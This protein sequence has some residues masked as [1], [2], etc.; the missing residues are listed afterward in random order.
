M[1]SIIALVRQRDYLVQAIR[2]TPG[3]SYSPA[4]DHRPSFF[5]ASNFLTTLICSTK[6][7]TSSDES[8]G[9]EED[10]NKCLSLRIEKLP[11]GVTVGSAL[12]S[13]MGDGFPVHG[14]DVY[15]AVNRLRKLGRNKRA[16]EL[17]EW[18][19]RERPYRLG[20]LEYSYLLE[21]TVKIHGISQAVVKIAP[22]SMRRGRGPQGEKPSFDLAS[23]LG[24]P[25]RR[26]FKHSSQGETLFTRVPQEFQNELLYNNLVI[27]CLDQGV[28]RLALGYMKKMRELG[29]RTSHLVY[30]RLIIRNSAPGRRKLIAKDL[31]LMKADKAVPHVSTYHILMK[32][33]ANEH[34]VDGVVK[35]FEGM[36]KV[37]VEPNEVSYCILAMA[38]A[39]ARLYTVAEAYTEEIERTIT[40]DNWSTLDMLMILYGRLGKEKEVERAWNVIK[41][42]HHV[43]SKSYLLATEAFGRVGNLDR[44]EEVWLEMKS[45]RGVKETEQFNSLLS[46]YCKRGLIEKAI[47]VFREMTG[48]GFKPNSITYRHLALGC[49]K[50]NLMKE[51]LKNIEMGSNLTTSRSVRS[52]TPWLETTLAIVECFAERGDVENSEKL[53]EELNDAKYNR[54]AFVYNAL[55]K[56]YVKGKVYDPNL[57]KRMVLGGARPDAESYSLLKLV[58]QFKS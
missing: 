53:F 33:E 48:D 49:A 31:A 58:E 25:R 36:K 50:A 46:V 8:D 1:R 29:H 9:A 55:F 27:A 47:G 3:V 22:Q 21:F 20:E 37:G 17:M 5:K 18:I 51:A 41:G 30:N 13:W 52:S 15:H 19:I 44:A 39:V 10:P 23:R 40:G 38:H 56:A 26:Y 43:R 24:S 57:F 14:G 34:N 28:M 12:Q 7:Q 42:F 4:L 35:A 54:Y 16:L 11:K 45:G 32:L 6:S 2:R